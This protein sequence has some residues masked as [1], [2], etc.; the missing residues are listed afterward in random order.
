MTNLSNF[1]LAYC[2][3]F[4]LTNTYYTEINSL[5]VGIKNKNIKISVQN[6]YLF[7][8]NSL[9]IRNV[10]I[11]QFD[12]ESKKKNSKFNTP[13]LIDKILTSTKRKE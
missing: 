5:H 10:H 13:K 4:S 7:N 9:Y 1:Q 6:L 11:Q 2:I 8:Q 12:P 3:N